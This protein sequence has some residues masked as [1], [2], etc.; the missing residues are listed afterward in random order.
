MYF[1]GLGNVSNLGSYISSIKWRLIRWFTNIAV[2]LIGII[3]D[4]DDEVM[5]ATSSSGRGS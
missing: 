3:D 2:S 5:A 4:D 1:W